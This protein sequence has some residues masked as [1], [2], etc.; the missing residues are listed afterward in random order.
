MS[1]GSYIRSAAQGTSSALRRLPIRWRLAGGAALT[2]LVILLGFAL[3]VGTLTTQRIRSDFNR[4][5]GKAADELQFFVRSLNGRLSCAVN[6]DVYARSENAVVRLVRPNGQVLCQTAN[7]PD[8]GRPATTAGPNVV[9]EHGGFRLESRPVR[10]DPT[11]EPAILEYGRELSSVNSTINRVRFLLGLGVVGG[12]GLALLAGLAISRRAMRPI[13]QLTATA[14]DIERTRDPNVQVPRPEA[15][16]EV[17]Q[18]A[19]TLERMLQSLDA[20]RGET[21]AALARQR[22]FVADAS[23]ELRTPLTSV[24]AN[25]EV[26][27][28]QLAGDDRETALAALR[29]SQRMR[30]LVADLLLLARA[31]AGRAAPR[32]PTDLADVVVEAAAELEPVADDHVLSVDPGAAVVEGARDE[33]HRMTTNLIA[34]ALRHTPPGT[35]VQVSTRSD[36]G[37][38]ELVVQDDGPGIP[39]D[40]ADRVFER[41]VRGRSDRG[42]GSTGLGLAIVRAVAESHGGTV[43]LAPAAGGRGARFV[44]RLPARGAEGA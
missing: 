9:R 37:H 44:V 13:S 22:E 38:A 42:G 40:L 16:D 14:R 18:L 21:E 25:L 33:L 30:R 11:G 19:R 2:T 5:V 17:A 3:V 27:A 6:F 20:A 29:S 1:P 31:D 28:D 7:A 23:H 39:A 12:A 15:D 4:Q 41:F 43:G 26:L 24:L 10:L 36:N 34:N 8:L 32:R 35:S